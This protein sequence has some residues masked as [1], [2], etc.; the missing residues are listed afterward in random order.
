MYT[1]EISLQSP[2]IEGEILQLDHVLK[3]MKHYTS[4]L[5]DKGGE[6]ATLFRR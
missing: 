1:S 3:Q 4:Y 6:K 5:K 2:D